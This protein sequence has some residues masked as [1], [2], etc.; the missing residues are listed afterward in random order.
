MT[1]TLQ[2]ILF[3]ANVPEL[4]D[5]LVEEQMDDVNGPA[6]NS[7]TNFMTFVAT[8]LKIKMGVAAKIWKQ[9][10]NYHA[11]TSNE[12]AIS[13]IDDSDDD[14]IEEIKDRKVEPTNVS[15]KQNLRSSSSSS[16]S[17]S[18]ATSS[19]S[20]SSTT[21]K[22]RSKPSSSTV[23]MPLSSGWSSIASIKNNHYPVFNFPIFAPESLLRARQYVAAHNEGTFTIYS[24]GGA[25]N[26]PGISGAGVALFLPD[27]RSLAHMVVY[28]GDYQT[29]NYAEYVGIIL[30]LT[31][32]ATFQIKH[33]KGKIFF[34]LI[35]PDIIDSQDS[36]FER[37]LTYISF[38]LNIV[39]FSL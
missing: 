14:E 2:D 20:T 38:F 7:I 1:T 17:S 5:S 6:F 32:A 31:L 4:F 21:S 24:D 22:K 26:N 30:G 36:P 28:L 35:L 34:L 12:H 10:E 9:L 29:N 19:T 16:A 27:G 3:R 33:L 39:Y 37:L 18:S 11:G 13:V 23:P 8:P 25:R 15:S